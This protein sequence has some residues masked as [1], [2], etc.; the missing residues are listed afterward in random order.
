MGEITRR[1]D[2]FWMLVGVLFWGLLGS[3]AM[4]VLT[5]DPKSYGHA[6]AFGVVATAAS[7][8]VLVLLLRLPVPRKLY[9]SFLYPLLGCLLVIAARLSNRCFYGW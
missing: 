5:S 2:L 3:T 7:T 1:K 4:N 9:I 8:F 6:L